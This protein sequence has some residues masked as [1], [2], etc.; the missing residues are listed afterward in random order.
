M[1]FLTQTFELSV[2]YNMVKLVFDT[3][4]YDHFI[5]L[6]HKLPPIRYLGKNGNNDDLVILAHP[7]DFC[8]YTDIFKKSYNEIIHN[9]TNK[10]LL[11][12]IK[13]EILEIYPSIDELQNI[14]NGFIGLFVNDHGMDIVK[15]EFN[16]NDEV[17]IVDFIKITDNGINTE[18]IKLTGVIDT[19]IKKFN[20]KPHLIKKYNGLYLVIGKIKEL[21]IFTGKSK[22]TGRYNIIGGK[23]CYDENSIES[24][25]R[26]SYEELGLSKDS[27]LYNFL[28]IQLPKVRDIIKCQTFNIYCLYYTPKQK[29]E[30]I[31][32]VKYVMSI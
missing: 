19:F 23:R 27:K 9:D 24:T 2:Y 13:T 1:K 17:D 8:K 11:D 3:I 4:G 30:Q 10:V 21:N 29:P 26:E 7:K 22:N 16:T 32:N 5:G 28:N 15:S 20:S 12:D 18:N 14:P 6:K 31:Y 25:I